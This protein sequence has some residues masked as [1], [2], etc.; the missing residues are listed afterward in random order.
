[1]GNQGEVIQFGDPRYL[2]P[3]LFRKQLETEADPDSNLELDPANDVWSMGVT[4]FELVSDGL[5]PFLYERCSL[6]RFQDEKGLFA[7]VKD[8]LLGTQMVHI[9]PHCRLA[10]PHLEQLLLRLLDKNEDGRISAQKVVEELKL[11]TRKGCTKPVELQVQQDGACQIL[12]NMVI[13]RLPFDH[14]KACV[15]VFEAFDTAHAGRISRRQFKEGLEKW[16][17]DSTCA[18]EVFDMADINGDNF[19]EFNE[20]AAMSFDWNSTDAALL[21]LHIGELLCDLS[22]D[23]TNAVD[24]A[25]LRRFFGDAIEE[26]VLQNL[27]IR[28]DRD[29][30]AKLSPAAVR[31]FLHKHKASASPAIPCRVPI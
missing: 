3:E 9:Q 8:V 11:S 31:T 19:L 21:E 14:V 18:D 27:F 12:F 7:R 24:L 20:F 16:A 25:D 13:W 10:T 28:I 26:D 2:S 29:Q 1:M 22:A 4:L 6:E 17:Q 15:D 30:S 5:L 23:G